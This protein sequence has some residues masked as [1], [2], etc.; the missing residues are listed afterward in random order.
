MIKENNNTI[1]G[2][3]DHLYTILC[4]LGVVGTY[5]GTIAEAV[6]AKSL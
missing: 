3:I 2:C 6:V 4:D 5:E 1:I